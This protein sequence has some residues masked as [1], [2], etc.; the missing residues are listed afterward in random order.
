M[1]QN[2]RLSLES[3]STSGWTSG[4]VLQ[5]LVISMGIEHSGVGSSLEVTSISGT[6]DQVTDFSVVALALLTDLLLAYMQLCLSGNAS[7]YAVWR[8]R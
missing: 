7:T 5:I 2:N 8:K 4:S 6:A 1:R 3:R